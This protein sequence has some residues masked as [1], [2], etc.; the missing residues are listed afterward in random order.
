MGLDLMRINAKPRVTIF[1][2]TTLLIKNLFSNR[3]L[4]NNL[5]R[6]DFKNTYHGHFLG[7]GWSLLEPLI[8]TGIFYMIIVLLRGS[9][10]DILPLNIML[11]ILLYSAFSKTLQSCTVSF[12][13]NSALIQQIYF[14]REVILSAISGFQLL[15]LIL[16]MFIV[17]PYMY[18]RIYISNSI[19][20]LFPIADY[21][22][23]C[24][25]KGWE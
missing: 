15:K 2:S 3:N 16:S 23:F 10:D 5:V 4:L 25:H 22:Q 9:S 13:R 1:N 12:T 18:L 8:F 6:R 19:M 17:I 21:R 14:P 20:I 11:G 7:Y 24:L